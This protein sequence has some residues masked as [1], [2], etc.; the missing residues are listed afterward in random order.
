MKRILPII[1]LILM[2]V[3]IA[4]FVYSLMAERGDKINRSQISEYKYVAS[5]L[6]EPFHYP[7]CRWAQKISEENLIGFKTRQQALD[8]GRRPCKVCKP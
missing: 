5:R 1:L 8:S 4:S 2:V 6:K 3:F 7:T